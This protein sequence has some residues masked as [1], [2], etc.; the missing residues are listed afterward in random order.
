MAATTRQGE[1]AWR[2]RVERKD[3]A[4]IAARLAKQLPELPADDIT[5]AIQ[6]HYAE[7]DGSRIRDFA[8]VAPVLPV[9]APALPVAAPAL[10]TAHPVLSV[11]A[12]PVPAAENDRRYPNSQ[13]D[14]RE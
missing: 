8:P 12:H 10:P 1:Q 14:K 7:F 2:E 9:A 5:H 3:L 6:G 13:Q 4:R 11:A